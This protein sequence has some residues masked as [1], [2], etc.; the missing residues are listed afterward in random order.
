MKLYNF[1]RCNLLTFRRMLYR[2][3]FC[4]NSLIT[5]S[6]WVWN[7][8]NR[9]F[10][11][12]ISLNSLSTYLL[13][14]VNSHSNPS[15]LSDSEILGYAKPRNAFLVIEGAVLY[16][17]IT[18]PSLYILTVRLISGHDMRLCDTFTKP[19]TRTTVITKP[20]QNTSRRWV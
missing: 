5:R 16:A 2:V 11:L 1:W 9:T 4:L 6:C 10:L 19:S 15:F 14:S 18:I 12:K 8:V 7:G 20:A 3:V 17:G 13:Y